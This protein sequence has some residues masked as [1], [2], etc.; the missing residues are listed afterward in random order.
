ML[1]KA[2]HAAA[3]L[4][5]VLV[6]AAGHASAADAPVGVK[7]PAHQRFVLPNGLTVVLVPKKDVPMIAIS[8][9]VRG[10]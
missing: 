8:G 7:V 5:L 9:F 3:A 1:S 4:W 2:C 10:G 6:L